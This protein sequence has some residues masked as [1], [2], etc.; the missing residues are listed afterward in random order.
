MKKLGGKKVV[1]IYGPPP[2]DMTGVEKAFCIFNAT[3][4]LEGGRVLKGWFWSH[5][6]SWEPG[7]PFN[8]PFKSERLATEHADETGGMMQ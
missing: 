2:T 6:I 5:G 3:I 7:E 1:T 8:G 4:T